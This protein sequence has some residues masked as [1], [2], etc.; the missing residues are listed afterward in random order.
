MAKKLIEQFEVGSTARYENGSGDTLFAADVEIVAHEGQSTA[1][2]KITGN[3]TG[4]KSGSHSINEM[5]R[6]V[7][8]F[9]L[10]ELE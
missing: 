6:G 4:P 1:E 10:F 8:R 9:E 3:L 5:V 7:K 2:I